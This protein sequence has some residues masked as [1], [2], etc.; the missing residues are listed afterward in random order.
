[1]TLFVV[2]LCMLLSLYDQ[3]FPAASHSL[4]H[5]FYPVP[6]RQKMR[7]HLGGS[8]FFY[9]YYDLPE[10]NLY[11]IFNS[12]GVGFFFVGT[13]VAWMYLAKITP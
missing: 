9:L 2:S 4:R 6:W 8:P 3:S 12:L 1:M 11:R 10:L 5:F 7:I 13:L